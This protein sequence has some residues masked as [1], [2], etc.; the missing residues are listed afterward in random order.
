MGYKRWRLAGVTVECYM[1]DGHASDDELA[2]FCRDGITDKLELMLI[3]MHVSE[4]DRCLG[5]VVQLRAAHAAIMTD[6]DTARAA[7]LADITSALSRGA[8]PTVACFERHQQVLTQF[9]QVVSEYQ[10]MLTAQLEAV[11]EGE[12]FPFDDWIEKAAARMIHAK[13]ELRAYRQEYG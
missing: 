3:M 4:C 10:G 6:D 1:D 12:D 13:H 7:V 8:C 2:L 5:K 11:V 9:A